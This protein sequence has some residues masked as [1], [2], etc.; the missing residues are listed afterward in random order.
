VGQ[1]LSLQHVR[2][3]LTDMASRQ[4]V[5][6]VVGVLAAICAVLAA[7][8]LLSW[9]QGSA[10]S[11]PRDEFIPSNWSATPSAERYRFYND[12]T[13]K[14]KLVGA[15]KMEIE[16]LLG[17]PDSAAPDG[18]YMTYLLKEAQGERYTSNFIYVLKLDVGPDGK[19]VDYRVVTD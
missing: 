13:G 17:K 1:L 7:P 5:L 10:I 8:L 15:T 6:I 19:I 16:A 3:V 14:M 4:K 2:A 11:W 12:L 18:R 9:Y